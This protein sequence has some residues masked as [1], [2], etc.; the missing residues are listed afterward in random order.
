MSRPALLDDDEE[1]DSHCDE[2][3]CDGNERGDISVAF[4]DWVQRDEQHCQRCE[5]ESDPD[6]GDDAALGHRG[7][8]DDERV[9]EHYAQLVDEVCDHEEDDA[10]GDPVESS[11]SDNGDGCEYHAHCQQRDASVQSVREA[12]HDGR[13]DDDC[14]HRSADSESEHDVALSKRPSPG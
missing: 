13:G 5:T 10:G 14:C 6:A 3:D 8:V 11:D 2:R 4:D 7:D 12:S 9:V 1:R